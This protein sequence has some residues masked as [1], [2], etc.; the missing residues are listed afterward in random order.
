MPIRT[1]SLFAALVFLAAGCASDSG[2][3]DYDAAAESETPEMADPHPDTS[4]PGWMPLFNE[5]LSNAID[6]GGVWA[7][8]EGVLTSSVDQG[9][10]T[11]AT[12]NDFV[13]DLEVMFDPG[14]N[15]GIIL[16]ATETD[17]SAWIPYSIEVQIADDYAMKDSARHHQES[18]AFYGHVP[19]SEQRIKPAGE[20][21]RY[22]VTARGDSLWTAL[23]GMEVSEI[24]MSEYHSA[25]TNPDGTSI[26][27]WLSN[28]LAELAT[29]G[30]I[31][32]QGKH[33]E[34]GVWFRN[35]MI[36][37]ME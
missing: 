13:L 2:D 1:L 4:E 6:P 26:P 21:N 14:A 32:I 8:E 16:H 36:K 19:P 35:L 22:T 30:H 15:S 12:Y 24:D 11:Q 10:F 23:N 37:P 28:P 3:A 20:W 17:T 31:G 29:E 27:P 7:W 33:G 25:E 18:G 9:L 34:T 5:D